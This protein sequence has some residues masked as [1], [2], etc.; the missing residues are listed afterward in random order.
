MSTDA[1]SDIQTLIDNYVYLV[2]EMNPG[3][4]VG[5]VVGAITPD[6]TSGSIVCSGAPLKSQGGGTITL[7]SATPFEIGS[8]SKLFTVGIYDMLQT[9]PNLGGT[10]SEKLP[11]KVSGTVG[12]IPIQCL[13]AYASGFPQDNGDCPCHVNPIS[14]KTTETLDALFKFLVGYDTMAYPTGTMYSYSNLAVSLLSMAALGLDNTDTNAFGNA[15]NTQLIKYCQTY[16]GTD[17]GSPPTTLVYNQA[18]IGSLPI[19]YDSNFKQW[20]LPPCSIVEYGSGGIVS[21]GND[22]LTFLSYAMSPNYPV[23]FQEY[24]WQNPAY[25][26]KNNPPGPINGYGWFLYDRTIKGQTMRMVSKDG[27][28]PGFSSWIG[29]EQRPSPDAAS[30]RGLFVLTNGPQATQLGA[31]AFECLVPPTSTTTKTLEF[32]VFSGNPAA[33]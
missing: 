20:T 26:L 11:L 8:V 25:C 12:S 30:P 27:G 24:R 21:C 17:K 22:M 28:V 16:V 3:V 9:E 1:L 4:Q 5:V 31:H 19:G 2:N 10:L 23:Y 7:S 13:A 14:G 29:L 18:D 15:Y 33:R 32:P 6:N